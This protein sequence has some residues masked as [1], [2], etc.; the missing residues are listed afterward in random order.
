MSTKDN[1]GRF[2]CYAAARPDEEMFVLLERD[3]LAPFLVSIWS[4]V[5]IGDPEAAR[6]MFEAMLQ[7]CAVRYMAEPDVDKAKEA[8]DCA[9]RM[10]QAQEEA[11]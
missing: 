3:Q 8:L 10:F 9:A 1:P 11:A 5:R 2:D 4:S 7:K 6:A